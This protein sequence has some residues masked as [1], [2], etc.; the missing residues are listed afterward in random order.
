MKKLL[1]VLLGGI[2]ASTGLAAPKA[3][4]AMECG[5]AADMAVVARS[6]AEEAVQRPQA[7]AIM[8]RIYDVSDSA[9]GKELMKDI[10]DAAYRTGNAADS[11]TFAEE[12][13]SACMKTGGN[14]DNVLGKR[15]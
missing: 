4:S 13:F 10:L 15:L 2:A 5:I 3:E 7:G 6:L 9:R 11:Q 1:A 14:M 12:L 8:A